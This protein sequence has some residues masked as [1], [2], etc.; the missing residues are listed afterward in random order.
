MIPNQAT[1]ALKIVKLVQ[2]YGVKIDGV[3]LQP[4][5]QPWTHPEFI[6]PR[7]ERQSRWKS[8]GWFKDWE[9]TSVRFIKRIKWPWGFIIYRTVYTPES[10]ELWSACLNK[11]EECVRREIDEFGENNTDRYPESI[12]KG[13]IKNVI[14]EAS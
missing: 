6:I 12:L 7:D 8:Q 3:G 5:W 2:S 9:R 13:T 10:D 11:I 14:L 1:G 4:S